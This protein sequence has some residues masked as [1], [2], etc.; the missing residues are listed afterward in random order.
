MLDNLVFYY[1]QDKYNK[2]TKKLKAFYPRCFEVSWELSQ[3]TDTWKKC[4]TIFIV[5]P[6]PL[7]INNF[8]SIGQNGVLRC[9]PL[10]IQWFN[11]VNASIQAVENFEKKELELML[12]VL[13]NIDVERWHYESTIFIGR[14]Q[15]VYEN[16]IQKLLDLGWKIQSLQPDPEKILHRDKYLLWHVVHPSRKIYVKGYVTNAAKYPKCF[17]NMTKV[18]IVLPIM[19]YDKNVYDILNETQRIRREIINNNMVEE[20]RKIIWAKAMVDP[21][22]FTWMNNSISLNIAWTF[23]QISHEDQKVAPFPYVYTSQEE[24]LEI[25][26][27]IKIEGGESEA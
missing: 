20:T 19:D 17:K 11:F 13:E 18:E 9:Y 12:E 15:T 27:Q 4:Y 5:N 6:I 2:V 14:S 23:L 8:H 21:E 25:L 10:Q 3:I 1:D 22:V 24:A 16:I 7:F 26:K